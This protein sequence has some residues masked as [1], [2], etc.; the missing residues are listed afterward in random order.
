LALLLAVVCTVLPIAGQLYGDRSGGWL[1]VD[2]RAY[3]CAALAQREHADPY[4]IH[5]LH[6]CESAAVQ[7]YYRAPANVTVPAPYPPYTLAFVSPLTRLPFGSAAILWWTLLALSI[8]VAIYALARITAQPILVAWG[9]LA[10]SLGLTSF[11]S[12]NVMPLGL[13]AILIAALCAQ[14]ERILLAVVAI[15]AAMIEP[16]VALPA[17][18]ALFARYRSARL[19]LMAAFAL[20][21]AISVANGGVARALEYATVVLPAHALSEVSRDNQYSLSTVLTA[22]GVPGASAVLAGSISYV[23][24]TALGVVVALRLAARYGDDAFALLVPPAFALLGGSFVHTAE[25]AAAVPA[26]LLLFT[27]AHDRRD[28]LFVALILLAVPWMLATSAAIFLAPLFPVGYLTFTLWRAKRAFTLVAAAASLAALAGLFAL[29]SVPAHAAAAL[30]LYSG[31]DPR[32]AEASWAQLVLANS[33]N[34]PVMWLLRLP[35][36]AGLG[37][38]AAV[39]I[40]LGYAAPR[41]A[42]KEDDPHTF[43]NSGMFG[44]LS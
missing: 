12:G 44:I 19:A 41:L 2:F 25:I 3:Y 1:M 17:A 23:L 31:I 42:R 20:L 9:A 36:W 21:G 5:P 24:A 8:A 29:A 16:Q 39:S 4:L 13:A 10:L 18:I 26:C 43:P 15:A 40:A 33:T 32:L 6:A 7:P 34:R 37:V 22:L 28:C 27:R 38:F 30:H 35:T 14:R 11:T